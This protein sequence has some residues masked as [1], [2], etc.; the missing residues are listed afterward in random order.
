MMRYILFMF[1]V[2]YPGGG[3]YDIRGMYA[4][5]EEAMPTYHKDEICGKWDK[6]GDNWFS[7]KWQIL[8]VETGLK[9]AYD[10][11]GEWVSLE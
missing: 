6:D 8:D 1:D 3:L 5:P 10:T 9:L 2:Y 7:D 11:N 4:T